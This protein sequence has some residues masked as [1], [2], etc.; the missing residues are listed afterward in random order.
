MK[1]I[2]DISN[3]LGQVPEKDAVAA[4][5]DWRQKLLARRVARSIPRQ[6]DRNSLPLSFA[7]ERLWLL[8]RL[9]PGS[10][11]YNRPLALRL[12]G[13]LDEAALRNALQ[14][15]V[16]RHEIL[17]TRFSAGTDQAVHV[18][19]S[20]CPLDLRFIELVVSDSAEGV[21]H[22]RRLATEESLR[23]FQ[24]E[25]EAPLRATLVRCDRQDHVLILVF[26]HMV[27]DGWSARVFQTE[28]A[29]LYRQF[30]NGESPSLPELPIQY[31]DFAHWERQKF[32]LQKPIKYWEGQL[33]GAVPLDLPTDRPRPS[34]QTHQGG[35]VSLI[36]P[37]NVANSLRVLARQEN[38]TLFMMLLAAFQTLLARYTGLEDITVGT[39]VAG[40]KWVETE[41]LIGIFINLLVMRSDL[42]GN[43]TFRQFL[44][45]VRETCRNAYS[46]QDLSFAKLV[47]ALKPQRDLSTTPLFQV[48]FNLENLPESGTEIPGLHVEEFDFERPV[49]DYELTLE[50]VPAGGQLKC[51][52]TYNSDIFDRGT[53]ERMAGHFRTLLEGI[54]SSPDGQLASFPMLPFSEAHQMLVEWNRTEADYPRDATIH[55]LF[56]AQAARTPKAIAFFSENG[57]LTYREIDRRSNQLACHLLSLGAGPESLVGVCLERSLDAVVSLLAILKAGA[58]FLPLDPGHPPDRLAFMIA[59]ARIPAIITRRQWMP[60]VAGK[61]ARVIC[62]DRDKSRIDAQPK[63]HLIVP[64]G[65]DSPAYLLYTSGSEGVPKGVLGLHRGAINRF[66]WM[67]KNFPFQPGEVCSLKTSLNFGDSIWELFG[68]LLQGVPSVIISG[69][70]V[71]E[72]AATVRMLA[73]YGVTRIVTVPSLLRA[74]L[75]SFPDLGE[76]L[77]RLKLWVSSGE[78]LLPGLCR[79]FYEAMPKAT[80]LNLYGSTEVSADVTAYVVP[81]T[82]NE[83]EVVS[84]GRPIDNT[85]C[86]VL[87]A[88]LQP[89]PVGARGDLYVGG[90]GLARGYCNRPELTAKRFIPDP[91]S[92][93]PGARLYRTGDRARFLPDGSLHYLGRADQQVKVR[94]YRIE[95]KEVETVLLSHPQVLAAVTAVRKGRSEDNRMVAYIV[96]QE[97]DDPPAPKV[98]RDFLKQKLPDYMVPADFFYLNALPLNSVGKIDRGALPALP[99]STQVEGG[100]VPAKDLLEAQLVK[101]WEELLDARPIGIGHDF[102]ELGGHSLLAARM[103]DRI[104]DAYGQRLP[105][106][107][108]FAGATINHLAECLRSQNLAMAGVTIVPVNAEGFRPP[109]FFLHGGGGLYCRKLS[110]LLGKDQPFYGVTTRDYDEDPSLVSVEAMAEDTLKLLLQM[111]PHGPYLLGGYC[112]GGLVAYEIARQMEARGLE[113][114]TVILLDVWVPRYFGWLKR[115]VGCGGWLFRQESDTKTYLYARMRAFLVRATSARHLGIRAFLRTCG[116]KAKKDFLTVA[117]PS[118]SS[119]G[120]P[121]DSAERIADL[122]YRGILMNYRPK[123]FFG[124]VVLLRTQEADLSYPT[125]PTSGW[126]SVA[127][128]VEVHNLPGDH[129]TCQTEH[130]DDVAQA[131]ST[132]LSEFCQKTESHLASSCTR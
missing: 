131:I 62:L 120:Q 42:S 104:E 75:Y 105:L 129:V 65:P 113:V 27:F 30:H 29:T 88:H 73:L 102:F 18:V 15:I 5:V 17:R 114:G 10:P 132:C 84:L 121:H 122:R 47:E 13:A 87:D 22:A 53:I 44:V 28:L 46:H 35:C 64:L 126:G 34:V 3:E 2:S 19:A 32:A 14:A 7:Q 33:S 6:T 16:D 50:V 69:E 68:P 51:Y 123:P 109:F 38:A 99:H 39:P 60:L 96:A 43:P 40:R 116:Q 91:F 76:R 90:D 8:E 9:E 31:A 54:L 49:A 11:S 108:L 107:T 21:A 12:T 118:S 63:D 72:P 23:P 77:P 57:N 98:L 45:R 24:L 92:S 93:L 71:R 4:G 83:R 25:H 125:D 103:M 86:Y 26:H 81:P 70:T 106:T 48:M 59:D 82:L 80:L 115:L 112:H 56:T 36:L 37:E 67:W 110:R 55:Q 127:A 89:V 119:P 58:A 41:N 74:M 97:L 20:G 128:Q 101:I 117:T 52:F 78:A 111:Q 100:Y 95:L 124:R 1:S 79:R 94:G 61:D 85:K 66:A 130:L